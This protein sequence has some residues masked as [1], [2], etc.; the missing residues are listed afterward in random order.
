MGKGKNFTANE[1]RC[2]CRS[3]LAVSQ[4]P[5]CGNGQRKTAFWERITTHFNRSKPRFAPTRPARSLES[6]WSH[7]KHDVAKFVG[8]HK[9]VSDAR[10]SRVSAEDVLERALEYYK[11]RH[12]KQQPFAFLHCWV[13]LKEVPRWW[14]SAMEVQRRNVGE[15][16]AAATM[17]RGRASRGASADFPEDGSSPG[18]GAEVAAQVEEEVLVVSRESFNPALLGRKGTKQRKPTLLSRAGRTPY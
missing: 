15:G 10:E 8:A 11:D 13:V 14:Q 1:E 4:D 2:L 17:A 9:Q 7:I 5:V 6:K 16:A 18:E 3:F 12:P